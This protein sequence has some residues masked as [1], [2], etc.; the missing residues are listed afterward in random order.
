MTIA[1]TCVLI[2]I[3]LPYGLTYYM[4]SG[5]IKNGTFD[6]RAPRAQLAQLEGPRRRALWAHDNSYESLPAFIAAVIIAHLA[7]A[8]QQVVDILAVIY[9]VSRILYI[10]CYIK[11]L[12][13]ARSLVW[14]IGFFAILGMFIAAY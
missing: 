8:S 7:G 1:F 14:G 13:T 5:L 10:A 12:A 2:A 6:N 4:K 11:D 3:L 9:L